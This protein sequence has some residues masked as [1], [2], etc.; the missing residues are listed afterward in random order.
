MIG[1]SSSLNKPGPLFAIYRTKFLKY[2]K[3]TIVKLLLTFTVPRKSLRDTYNAQKP[4]FLQQETKK[5]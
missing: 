1:G 2:A 4:T 3:Y 5:L